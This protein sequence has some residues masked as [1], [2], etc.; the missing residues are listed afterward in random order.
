M[1]KEDAAQ[2]GTMQACMQ[3][4]ACCGMAW[5]QILSW[6]HTCGTCGHSQLLQVQQTR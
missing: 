4:A 1:L 3:V 2:Q 6:D 5:L